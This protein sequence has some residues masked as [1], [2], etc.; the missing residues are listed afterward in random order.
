MVLMEYNLIGCYKITKE[1]SVIAGNKKISVADTTCLWRIDIL[2]L[3]WRNILVPNYE[4]IN[5]DQMR[6]LF[7]KKLYM[8]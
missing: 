2:Q 4:Y 8:R 7:L 1:Q 3:F 6:I 5:S